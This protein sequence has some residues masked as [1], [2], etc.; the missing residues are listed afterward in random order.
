MR[1]KGR[2]RGSRTVYSGAT[3]VNEEDPERDHATQVSMAPAAME[4]PTSWSSV[5]V[6]RGA[7]ETARQRVGS[8]V[9]MRGIEMRI[10]FMDIP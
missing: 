5:S 8:V 7:R 2:R 10:M 4:F 9:S 6:T 3:A 1:G